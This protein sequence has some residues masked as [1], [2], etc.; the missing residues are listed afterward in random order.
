VLTLA[1]MEL[2]AV[3]LPP[4]LSANQAWGVGG[5]I[6]GVLVMANFRRLADLYAAV[7]RVDADL[8]ERA[9]RPSRA[10]EIA[11]IWLRAGAGDTPGS[12]YLRAFITFVVGATIFFVGLAA[13]LGAWG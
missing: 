13:A 7:E 9:A 11:S 2:L 5:I 6:L 1:L 4:A 10:R 12:R 8:L 3:A